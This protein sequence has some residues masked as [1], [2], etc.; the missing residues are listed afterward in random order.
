MRFRTGFQ[1][2]PQKE[3]GTPGQ[4]KLRSPDPYKYGKKARK[5]LLVFKNEGG[6]EGTVLRIDFNFKNYRV[7]N[8]M[9]NSPTSLGKGDRK[10]F[11]LNKKRDKGH[12][13][14]SLA[15][16]NTVVKR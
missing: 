13:K 4:E 12:G 5:T 7:K 2:N 8:P 16:E 9:I 11:F 14:G 6:G 15:P 1:K 10:R 3:G